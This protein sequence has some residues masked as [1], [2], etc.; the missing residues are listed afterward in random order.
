MR[1]V[2][3]GGYR[4][5]YRK[6]TTLLEVMVVLGFVAML[7]AATA[8]YN[9]EVQRQIILTREHA[10]ALGLFVRARSA[11]LTYPKSPPNEL[12][13]GYGVHVDAASR[14]FIYFKDLGNFAT[15]S[16]APEDAS[17]DYDGPGERIEQ[18]VLSNAVTVTSN[19][20]TDIVYVPPFGRVYTDGNEALDVVSIVIA[21]A[22]ENIAKGIRANAFGQITEFTPSTP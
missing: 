9:K 20:A 19:D 21:R 17:R 16:C 5:A 18:K 4:V 3:H 8:V 22:D 13:C 15:Q 1:K 12:I 11:A 7:S 2:M 6:G 14:T 10:L